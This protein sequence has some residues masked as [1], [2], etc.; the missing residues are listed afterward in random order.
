[1][2]DQFVNPFP[3]M[4]PYLE[5]AGLWP[6]VHN[7]LID[8]MHYFLRQALPFRYWV[9]MEER[10][11]I[12][13]NLPEEP[14][15]RYARPDIT[16]AG[17][18]G[19]DREGPAA[20]ADGQAVAVVVPETYPV[21]EWYL[22]I[23]ERNRDTP[24]AV[25]EIL[26]PTNKRPG[27]SRQQYI[28]KRERILG[29]ATHLIEIDLVRAGRPMPIGGYDGDAPY[30]ILISRWPS[31]PNADLYPFGLSDGIPDVK[32]PLLRGDEEPT[33]PLGEIVDDVYLRSYYGRYVN[34]N[35]DLEEPLSGSD[36]QWLDRML[37]A[38]GLRR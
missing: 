22:E 25:L 12:G 35:D 24:V 32:T 33:I 16:I 7:K 3:G 5:T 10:I 18:G 29:S 11:A 27:Y 23:T 8:A 4:N 34:Y 14:P 38:K 26:S 6:E 20:T 13:Q 30:S 19:A 2:A 9:V 37:R 31:R 28:A 1:M 21:H 17:G 36:R 15:E